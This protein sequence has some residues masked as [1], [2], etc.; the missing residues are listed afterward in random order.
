MTSTHTP[1]PWTAEHNFAGGIAIVGAHR[2]IHAAHVN[3]HAETVAEDT[4]NAR[5]IAAAPDMLA[6]LAGMLRSF[7]FG[8]E[9]PTDHPIVAARAA[10]AQ[11]TA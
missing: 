5:L 3:K 10:I 11:A 4:A 1:G 9:F 7:D 8:E 2:R 6:A